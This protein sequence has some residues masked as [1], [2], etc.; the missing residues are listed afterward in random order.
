MEAVEQVTKNEILEG[1]GQKPESAR[2]IAFVF[3][4]SEYKAGRFPPGLIG[5]QIARGYHLGRSGNILII[6]KP[7]YMIEGSPVEHH[8]GYSY[9]RTVPLIFSG[10]KIKPGIY[11]QHADIVD[12]APTLSFLLSLVPPSLSEGRVLS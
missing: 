1:Y 7:F 8:T 12:I 3:T 6:P 4:E 9:D 11:S 10:R 5:K 2:G